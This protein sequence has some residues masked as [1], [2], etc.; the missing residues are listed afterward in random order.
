MSGEVAL[1]WKIQFPLATQPND[2]GFDHW[3]ATQNNASPSHENPNNF[4]RNGEPVGELKGYS[5]QL[6]VDEAVDWLKGKHAKN[7]EQP[8]FMYVAFQ[9]RT[10]RWPRP[11]IWWISMTGLREIMKKPSTLPMSRTWTRRWVNY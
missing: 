1:Q 7:K 2:A 9:S 11:R 10:S 8:F 4:V 3:F 6:V 5:C